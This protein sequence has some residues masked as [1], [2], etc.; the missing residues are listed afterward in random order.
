MKDH[1]IRRRGG[2][3]LVGSW[4]GAAVEQPRKLPGVDRKA[5][6]GIILRDGNPFYALGERVS[7]A[8]AMGAAE[9]GAEGRASWCD[10]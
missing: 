7:M 4:L 2:R 10:P 8:K 6:A 9:R 1:C 5:E 3:G